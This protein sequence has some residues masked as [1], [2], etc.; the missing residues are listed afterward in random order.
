MTEPSADEP[1]GYDRRDVPADVSPAPTG[2][3]TVPTN[4]RPR[5]ETDRLVLRVAWA[6]ALPVVIAAMIALGIGMLPIV[7]VLG[8]G[9]MQ[10]RQLAFLLLTSVFFLAWVCWYVSRR[11]VLPRVAFDK[12]TEMLILG[13]RG[14]RGRRPL[15]SVLGVQVM[16]TLK[17]FGRPELNM[18]AMTMYQMNL[19]LDD[20]VE[21]RLNVLTC[22]AATARSTAQTVADFLGVPVLDSAGGAAAAAGAV[23]LASA[24]SASVILSPVVVEPKPDVLIIRPHF[25]NGPIGRYWKMLTPTIVFMGL[26]VAANG[27]ALDGFNVAFGISL[28]GLVICM[29][30]SL[31]QHWRVVFDRARGELMVRRPGIRAA[32]RP[33]ESVKAVEVVDGPQHALNLLLDD[34]NQPRLNLASDPDGAL[35]RR[36]A[37]RVASFL[38]VPLSA[39][40]R[41]GPNGSR[42]ERGN[43]ARNPVEMLSRSPLSPGSATIRGSARVRRRGDDVL[44]LQRRAGYTWL[45]LL[46]TLLTTG[47]EG[48]ILWLFCFGPAAG[49]AP[50]GASAVAMLLIGLLLHL[51]AFKPLFLYYDHFDRKAGVL[52]MGWFGFKGKHPLTPV[53]AVQLIPGGLV[54]KSPGRFG[55]GGECVSY[56]MNLATADAYPDRLNL[57]D[58]TDLRWTRQAGRQIADFLGVPL[59]DQIAEEG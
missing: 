16:Q 37:E 57:T 20:P 59:I 40:N 28:A 39:A 44:I 15:S 30:L 11:V 17:R 49:Q 3:A 29:S 46:P 24:A 31:F 13:W 2:P 19:I 26:L 54:D 21:Q 51:A 22:D 56:Q 43:E 9:N 38:G 41:L 12:R 34:I 18:P 25:L 8:Q 7:L 32:P 5:Q 35:V 33:L 10:R 45:R 42:L 52:R 58:D 48:Y 55:R 27:G 1:L 23:A 6:R 4:A 53:V 50:L 14:V 36:V 47:V